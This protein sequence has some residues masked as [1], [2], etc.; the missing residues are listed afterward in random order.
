MTEYLQEFKG[1]SSTNIT[2]PIEKGVKKH[3]KLWHD[4]QGETE[5]RKDYVNPK[6]ATDSK[7]RPNPQDSDLFP[8]TA[9][10]YRQDFNAGK[11]K[12]SQYDSTSIPIKVDT[13]TEYRSEYPHGTKNLLASESNQKY[14]PFT[15]K[16]K[17]EELKRSNS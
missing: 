8:K 13:R 4:G 14:E 3:D 12:S 15:G 11:K 16:K 7:I 17:H 5:Y 9:T 10:T 2:N 6:Y 1:N